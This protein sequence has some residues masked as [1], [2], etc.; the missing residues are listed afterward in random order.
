MPIP[1]VS[2]PRDSEDIRA[3]H[4]SFFVSGRP[5]PGGSRVPGISK[6]GKA[7][8]RPASK[9]T[10]QWRKDVAA[11]AKRQPH[12]FEKD[13]PLNASFTFCVLRPKSHFKKNGE[14]KLDAPKYPVNPADTTKLVRSTEDALNKVLWH[15][16]AAV[17]LQINRKIYSER[18]GCH[19]TCEELA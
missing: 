5:A 13:V 19:I 18:Q 3:L 10:E 15:D 12:Y 9:Y 7:F 6:S 16:D 8:H 2:L 4:V 11:A 17:V 1:G 14:L